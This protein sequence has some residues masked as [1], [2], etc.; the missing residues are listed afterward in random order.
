MKIGFIRPIPVYEA[1]KFIHQTSFPASFTSGKARRGALAAQSA[2]ASWRP[3]EACSSEKAI[4]FFPDRCFHLVFGAGSVND[5][6]P[7]GLCSG[8]FEISA[9]NLLEKFRREPFFHPI[10]LPNWTHSAQLTGPG[11]G[12]IEIQKKG[13]GRLTFSDHEIVERLNKLQIQSSTD[14]LV[15]R[16]RIIESVRDDHRAILHRGPEPLRT[17]WARLAAKS[18]NS[19]SFRIE[20]PVLACSSNCRIA[21]PISVKPGSH[22]AKTGHP[23]FFEPAHQA[24]DLGRFPTRFP[25]F[26][27]N[28]T[29][30]PSIGR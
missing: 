1:I 16:G 19:V 6:Y 11:D 15:D 14:S 23:D 20:S 29:N 5:L 12:Y 13:S 27:S 28:Q 22:T 2:S 4:D 7:V 10:L 24:F 9:S 3:P 30:R 8:D 21:V 26:K 17:N 18:S 25:P